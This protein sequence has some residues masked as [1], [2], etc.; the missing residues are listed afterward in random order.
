MGDISQSLGLNE[1]SRDPVLCR[2]LDEAYLKELRPHI[3]TDGDH[4][5]VSSAAW[6]SYCL[7]LAVIFSEHFPEWRSVR[8]FRDLSE[9]YRGCFN[10]VITTS[11][12]EDLTTLWA[13]VHPALLEANQIS[14]SSCLSVTRTL[15]P[16]DPLV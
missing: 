10:P 4:D 16:G 2:E 7:E 12:I 8:F 1:W 13:K 15:S 5:G 9:N 14:P 11:Y 6:K 3:Q